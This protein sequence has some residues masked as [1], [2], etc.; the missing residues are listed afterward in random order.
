MPTKTNSMKFFL[1][2]CFFLLLFNLTAQQKTTWI[3]NVSIVNTRD[4]IIQP[5]MTVVLKGDHIQQLV[6]YKATTK[7]PDS[8]QLIDGSGKYLMPGMIDGHIHFFQ[9]GGL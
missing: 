2:F 5:A 1:S 6:K 4:G 3:T 9:S 7:I 8:V